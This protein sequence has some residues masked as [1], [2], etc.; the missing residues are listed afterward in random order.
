MGLGKFLHS[1]VEHADAGGTIER[2]RAYDIVGIVAFAGQRGRV[3]RRLAALSGARPGDRVL[4]VGC[5][6]GALTRML[7]TRVSTTGTATGLDPSEPMIEYARHRAPENCGY[8]VGEAQDLPFDDQSFAVIASS[9]AIH[10]I[11]AAARQA[12]F[13]EMFRVL[14]P[15]GRL[16]IADFRPPT[17]PIGAHLIGMV[18]GPAMAHNP[19]DKLA[20]LITGAGFHVTA[21]GDQW[22]LL[23]YLQA[24]R[25]T[26]PAALH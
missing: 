2:A 16:L 4:D 14:R 17:N 8:V 3:F 12:A 24:T 22:P 7:A 23:H 10:H 26:L 21:E 9:Y 13:T 1:H 18:S 6:T 5:G 25:P 15:G 19:I 20:G 11:P